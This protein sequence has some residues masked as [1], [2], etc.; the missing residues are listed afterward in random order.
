MNLKV[1]WVAFAALAA[2]TTSATAA[3]VTT[4]WSLFNEEGENSA[5][6]VY[7]TYGS[8]FDMMNDTNRTGSATPDGLNIARNIV[9]SGAFS[10]E[11]VGV[12]PVPA[13]LPLAAS[14]LGILLLVGR[15]KRR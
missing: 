2:L 14:A 6:S 10:V 15:R 8:L 13:S 9:G 1:I 11:I 5:N 12:I 4:Y 3:T 7:V